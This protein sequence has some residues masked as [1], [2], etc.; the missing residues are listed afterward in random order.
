MAEDTNAWM[1]QG[2]HELSFARQAL[3]SGAND[4]ACY[5]GQQ[6]LEKYLKGLIILAERDAPRTQNLDGLA[7]KL[8][9]ATGIDFTDADM[10]ALKEVS[11]FN[12]VARYPL[13]D[14]EVAPME[15]ITRDQAEKTIDVAARLMARLAP[16]AAEASGGGDDQ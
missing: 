11:F 4:I 12:V 9:D 10:D 7:S 16:A 3:G 2:E 13:G 1:R 6:A 14:E 15:A 5:L 8:R